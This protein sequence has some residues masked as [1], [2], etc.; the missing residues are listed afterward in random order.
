MGETLPFRRSP[1]ITTATESYTL[2]PVAQ[3]LHAKVYL[4]DRTRPSAVA[5]LND[6]ADQLL[7]RLNRQT[8]AP[9]R[10][11]AVTLARRR[12]AVQL[13]ALETSRAIAEPSRPASPL[14]RSRDIDLCRR[15]GLVQCVRWLEAQTR[16]R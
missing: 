7:P 6:I 4:L 3:A 15:A 5:M 16:Q 10:R 13:V 11:D 8:K 1:R 2:S 12:R 14:D 9:L